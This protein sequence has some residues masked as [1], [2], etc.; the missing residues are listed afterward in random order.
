MNKIITVNYM[1]QTLQILGA[2]TSQNFENDFEEFKAGFE[3]DL[4]DALG[5]TVPVTYSVSD[6]D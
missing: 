6:I 4:K 3:K 5:V 2:Q 1:G